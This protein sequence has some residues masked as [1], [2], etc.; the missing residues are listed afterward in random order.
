MKL[1]ITPPKPMNS[2]DMWRSVFGLPRYIKE[3]RTTFEALVPVRYGGAPTPRR[4][5]KRKAGKK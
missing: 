2:F 4:R 5:A 3:G 1:G